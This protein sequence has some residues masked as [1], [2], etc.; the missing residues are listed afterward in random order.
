MLKSWDEKDIVWPWGVLASTSEMTSWKAEC[1]K[2]KEKKKK[3]R[4]KHRE[5]DGLSDRFDHT[6]GMFMKKQLEDV[7]RLA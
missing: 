6:Q 7:G 2:L 4:W 5:R 1:N 3:Q